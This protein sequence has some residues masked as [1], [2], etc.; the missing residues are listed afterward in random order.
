MILLGLD[1]AYEPIRCITADIEDHLLLPVQANAYI[2]WKGT[3]GFN[4]HWDDH[5]TFIA[6]VHGRKRWQVYGM[7]FAH[8]LFVDVA[9]IEAPPVDR[10]VWSGYVESGDLLYIPRGVWHS[11][12]A[13]SGPSVHLTFALE[14]A[15]G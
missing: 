11:A 6:Q 14:K 4:V 5:D 9:E 8:P 15:N 2:S 12:A 10:P 13:D 1:K 7:T 3:P